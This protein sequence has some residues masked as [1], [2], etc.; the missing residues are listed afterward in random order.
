MKLRETITMNF[1]IFFFFTFQTFLNFTQKK[2]RRTENHFVIII[3]C[4]NEKFRLDPFCM[5][6]KPIGKLKSNIHEKFHGKRS[7]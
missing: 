6:Q 1:P 2:N 4:K 5:Q 7:A 3:G